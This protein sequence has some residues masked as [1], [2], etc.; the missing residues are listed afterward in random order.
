MAL[1][2]RWAEHAAMASTADMP[3]H[4]QTYL[5]VSLFPERECALF[6][7]VKNP[8]LE[9]ERERAGTNTRPSRGDLG[10]QLCVCLPP[11]PSKTIIGPNE[12]VFFELQTL[13]V[14]NS[15]PVMRIWQV[16]YKSCNVKKCAI[17]FEM[18]KK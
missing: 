14:N 2:R 16:A 13:F 17:S 7:F 8:T 10:A 3:R 5:F 12:N 9:R 4:Q 1:P 15:Q 6:C 18:M 11:G